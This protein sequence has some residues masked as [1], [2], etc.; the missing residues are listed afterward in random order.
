M[1]LGRIACERFARLS[2]EAGDRPLRRLEQYFV[3]RHRETCSACR[4]EEAFTGDAL[5]ML[6]GVAFGD[7]DIF[8]TPGFDDRIIRQVKVNTV[9]DGFRYWSPAAFGAVVAMC[10]IFAAM[11]VASTPSSLRE[12]NV[13]GGQV[14]NT[15]SKPIPNLELDKIPDF[16]R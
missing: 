14:R 9:R 1:N 15:T 11:H 16:R 10:A 6:R 4:E 13:P 5:N 12:A 7:E 3:D 8:I 2:Q